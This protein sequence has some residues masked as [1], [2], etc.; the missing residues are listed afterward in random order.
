MNRILP[1]MLWRLVLP[2]L[3]AI[4]CAR[5]YAGE[6]GGAIDFDRAREL[7]RKQR[8]G[9]ALT[10]V[11]KAYIERARAER[12]KGRQGGSAGGGSAPKAKESTGLVPLPDMG[13]ARYKGESGGLYGEGKNTPPAAH[14]ELARKAT[15]QI[16][17][18]D[19]GGKPAA[20]GKIVLISVGMSNTSMEF[21]VFKMTADR[22][23]DKSPAVLV[24]NG[25]Q[26]GKD[27]HDW[28][29]PDD[30]R[31]P[32][33]KPEPWGLLAAT[34]KQTGVTAQQ[35]QVAWIKQA[36]AA[37]RNLGEFPKHARALQANLADIARLLKQRFPNM[38][39]TYL[40][41]RTY[42]GYSG[43][44][45]LNPEPEAYEGGFAVRW[46]IGDQVSGKGNLNADPAKGRVTAP[47]L[48]WGPYLWADGLKGRKGDKLVWERKDF[49]AD[50]VHPSR[51]GQTKVT[52][53]LLGFFKSDPLA[54][55]WFL[56]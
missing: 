49:I 54:R 18:L 42:G 46:V 24:V 15:A 33:K 38:R 51:N 52:G 30:Q 10:E 40:S 45:L 7:I 20:N 26:G 44:K 5:A 36:R 11:E 1:R 2:S 12:R 14:L 50:G 16:R 28:A 35:V 25:A 43:A 3:L 27:A 31:N 41:S 32:K 56:K 9:Q 6:S 22:D 55:T 23:A 47:V 53:L 13:E 21:K 19:A 4:C 8:Q 48:L 29:H 39:V 37:P 34:L 17:P